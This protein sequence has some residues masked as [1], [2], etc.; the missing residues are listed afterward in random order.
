MTVK[1]GAPIASYSLDQLPPA[2]VEVLPGATLVPVADAKGWACGAFRN[3]GSFCTGSRIRTGHTHF[4]AQPAFAD[5]GEVLEGRHLYAGLGRHHFGHFLLEA[6]PRLWAVDQQPVDGIV[7]MARPGLDFPAVLNRRFRAFL[8]VLTGGLPIMVAQKPTRVDELV[9]AT[10]GI[11]HLQWITGTPEYR[12]FMRAR[13]TGHIAPNG[14]DKIYISRSALK[15][16][17]QM[18]DQ[19]ERIEGMM[20]DAGYTIVHPQKLSLIE[21]CSHYMAARHIVGGDGSAFHLAALVLQPDT[22]VAVIQRRWRQNVVDAIMD[23]ISAFSEAR[24]TMINPLY[25]R[26]DTPD[27]GPIIP[28]PL[29]IKYLKRALKTAGFI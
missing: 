29:D 5:A 8:D 1:T 3:D 17:E 6:L 27:N 28:T 9:V 19:E 25:P 26:E 4:S 10:P 22:Q 12:Q 18:V 24:L 7:F 21:Q 23:Q 13:L 20:R 16:P 15:R 14:P 2:L 11:G